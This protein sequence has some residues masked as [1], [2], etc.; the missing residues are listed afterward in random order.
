MTKSEKESVIIK[1]ANSETIAA[2]FFRTTD[3]NRA[4]ESYKD[5]DEFTKTLYSVAVPVLVF[6]GAGFTYF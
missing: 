3:L 2:F 1:L 6:R 5:N 4:L